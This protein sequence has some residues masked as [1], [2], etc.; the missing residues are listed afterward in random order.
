MERTA[1]LEVLRAKAVELLELEPEQ[2][3]EDVSFKSDLHVDS[4]ALVEYTMALEDD[5]GVSLPEEEVAEVATIGQF[6]DLLVSKTAA[7]A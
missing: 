2:I 6:L 4:L 5:L 1:L 7:A 3:Q